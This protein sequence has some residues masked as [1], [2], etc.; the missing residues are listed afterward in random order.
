MG[1]HSKNLDKVI[2]EFK[3]VNKDLIEKLLESKSKIK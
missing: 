1:K 3:Q 2:E